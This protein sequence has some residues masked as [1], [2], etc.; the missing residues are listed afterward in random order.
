[1]F[2]TVGR[3]VPVVGTVKVKNEFEKDF[4]RQNLDIRCLAL[5]IQQVSFLGCKGKIAS[6]IH[7]HR[8]IKRGENGMHLAMHMHPKRSPDVRRPFADER[9]YSSVN[10]EMVRE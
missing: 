9:V 2:S 5:A 3:H 8:I 10:S 4:R 7:F 1:M 6:L